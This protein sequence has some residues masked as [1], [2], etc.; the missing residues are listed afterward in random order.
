MS[1]TGPLQGGGQAPN[2]RGVLRG[3]PD[4][5]VGV[6]RGGYLGRGRD[7]VA[8]LACPVDGAPLDVGDSGVICQ[9]DAA[10]VYPVEA[11]IVRLVAAGQ[12]VEYARRSDEHE[13]SCAAQGWKVPA[14]DEFKALPQTGLSGYPPGYWEGQAAATALLWRYLEAI[15]LREGGL[16]VG[17]RGSAAVLGAG[18]GWLAYALDA[19]GYTTLAIDA[20]AGPRGGLGAYPFARYLR[21]QADPARPPL[22][23]AQFDLAVIQGG[24][25]SVDDSALAAAVRALRPGG[26][27]AL[28]DGVVP[29]GEAVSFAPRLAEAGLAVM[30]IPPSRR[31]RGRLRERWDRWT[32]R[33]VEPGAVAVA[34]K[35][36]AG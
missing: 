28:V 3:G 24:L 9:A 19:G 21:V 2:G 11:G 8:L 30:D 17:P 12:R 35:P 27:L 20:L 10:H 1:D 14:E 5:P 4:S 22:A 13:A 25:A 33:A 18:L 26:W 29:P 7:Y 32:G 31:W 16:P 6:L 34:Q 15:R 23:G 36:D